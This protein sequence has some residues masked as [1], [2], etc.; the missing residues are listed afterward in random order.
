MATRN[1]CTYPMES[2]LGKEANAIIEQDGKLKRVNLDWE[3]DKKANGIVSEAD[4]EIIAVKDSATARPKNIILCGKSKQKT[5]TGKNLFKVT[6]PETY[7]GVT[8]SK[9][10]DYYVL[11]GTATASALFITK[12]G[13]LEA[14]TYALSANNPKHNSLGQISVPIVQVYSSTTL[15]SI[16]AIDD[17][18][19]KTSI[20]TI[21]G[22]ENYETRIR[23]QEGITYDNFIIKPQFERNSVVTEY[24]PYTGGAPSP[25][26]D[27][28]QEIV[29]VDNPEIKVYGKNFLKNK[30]AAGS[31]DSR[32]GLTFIVNEDG[33]VTVN[34][35]ATVATGFTFEK[36]YLTKDMILSGCPSGGETK[37][38]RMTAD[39][40]K[41]DKYSSTIFDLGE[42]VLLS[43]EKGDYV[44]INIYVYE[45]I[46][47]NNLT[48]YP[49]VRLAEIKDAT[50]E[51]YK[52]PQAIPLTHTLPGI[53]VTG[54]TM[55]TLAN[56]TDADGLKWIC[57]EVDL[58]RGVY[59]QRIK[60]M[61]L[62]ENTNIWN[63]AHANGQTYI[64]VYPGDNVL[65]SIVRSTHYRPAP[66]NWSNENGYIYCVER[67]IVLVD[68]RFSTIEVAKE[69]LKTER[70]EIMYVLAEPIETP[71]T[72]AEIYAFKHTEMNY[73][74]TTIVN[75]AGAFMKLDYF[76]DTLK[77]L[78][79]N[80]GGLWTLAKFEIEL[81]V[82][83]WKLSEDTTYYSQ[84]V[85]VPGATNDT[86]VDLQPTPLQLISL[87]NN[88]TSMF[89]ANEDGIIKVYVVGTKP[90]TDMTMQATKM[91]VVYV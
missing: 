21:K 88:G 33:S 37:T 78:V 85:T 27:W 40:Y 80:G 89:A 24:E 39:Y 69:I 73:P 91:E 38:Y 83:G 41:D 48:F 14:G 70:P 22:G 9:K 8:L 7:N 1:I 54:T 84:E 25:R 67:A 18:V 87:M 66:Q 64:S 2:A 30:L 63:G 68:S 42:G 47:I 60:R 65:G 44:N 26:P 72:D 23:I 43:A 81:P 16:A 79:K 58:E 59:V 15:E 31:V 82:S 61:T 56:Y 11:N 62:D 34:G 19:N 32:S 10:D 35:T 3:F 55:E 28:P 49:M 20:V 36:L 74:N 17:A 13:A 57:D 5:T 4:G 50:Y 6:A 52:E 46:T 90:N 77:F 86:K 29:S 51:P 12:I 75:D 53:D 45:G 76:S 71:L